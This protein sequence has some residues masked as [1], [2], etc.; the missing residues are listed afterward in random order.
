M[1]YI[2]IQSNNVPD[3]SEWRVEAIEEPEGQVYLAIFCGP[4]AQERA[5]EYAAWKNI[6]IVS[7]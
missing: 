4:E 3:N 6:M 2:A 5:I 7:T 1:K